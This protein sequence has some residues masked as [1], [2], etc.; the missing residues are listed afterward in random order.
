MGPHRASNLSCSRWKTPYFLSGVA[1]VTGA[2]TWSLCETAIPVPLAKHHRLPGFG[3]FQGAST[4]P[5]AKWPGGMPDRGGWTQEGWEVAASA[6]SMARRNPCTKRV[7]GLDSLQLM[8]G[9]RAE[10]RLGPA[11]SHNQERL[12]LPPRGLPARVG[13]LQKASGPETPP[14]S[15]QPPFSKPPLCAKSYP[16]P[17]L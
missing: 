15:L 7:P 13:T 8:E 16:G 2:K 14:S 4:R 1:R 11:G 5:W 10:S 17:A 12:A 3:G 9:S 6:F